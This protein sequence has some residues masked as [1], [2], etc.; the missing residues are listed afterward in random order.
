M[1]KPAL[2]AIASA[3]LALAA[4][5]ACASTASAS[6]SDFHIELVDLAPGDGV[7]PSLTF[8]DVQGG[9]FV[10]AESGRPQHVITD[11]N[12]GG[13]AFGAAASS[14]TQHGAS[15]SASLSGDPFG[16]PGVAASVSSTSTQAGMYGASTVQLG[17]GALVMPFTLSAETRLVITA[18]ASASA[19]STFLDPHADTWA[20]VFLKLTDGSGQ[21]SVSM[22]G[23]DVEQFA[24]SG[25]ASS[26]A[27]HIEISF[28]NLTGAS[29]DGLFFGSIDTY[30]A[31]ISPAPEPANAALMAAALGLFAW[32]A[33][34]RAR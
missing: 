32:R 29:L 3:I 10:A 2:A 4:A 31:D 9:P 21:G 28:E 19:L 14:S 12:Q 34:R 13:T 20:S 15:A 17:D 11:A 6:L 5:P 33:T 24:A 25:P 1:R 23:L 26:D 8:Q 7:A 22:D 16:Q 18:D 30:A 27:K